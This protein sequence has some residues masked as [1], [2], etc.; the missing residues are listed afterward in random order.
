VKYFLTINFIMMFGY[1]LSIGSIAQA[2][3]VLAAPKNGPD[4]N[5]PNSVT[6]KQQTLSPI[7]PTPYTK[8]TKLAPRLIGNLRLRYE[9]VDQDDI[10]NAANALTLRYRGTLETD[11]GF[12][13]TV[14]GEIEA[15]GAIVTDF[16]DGSGNR[17]DRPVIPEPDGIEVNRL[18]LLTQIN[19]NLRITSGRQ[20]IIIDDERFIGGLAFR[21]N[22][23]TFDSIRINTKILDDVLIDAAYIGRTQ[24]ILGKNNP[25]GEFKGDSFLININA[26][27]PLG[28]I[29]AFHY[30]LD[31]EAGTNLSPNLG[32]NDASVQTTGLRLIGRRHW[33]DWGVIWEGSYAWQSD[34][35]DS[36]LDFNTD[37][38][39]AALNLNRGAASLDLRAEIL[40]SDQG[41]Q[42]FQTPLGTLHK[43]QGAAD[44]FL[45]TPNAGLRDFSTGLSW[46]FDPIGPFTGIKAN[47]TYHWFESD[48]GNHDLGTEID[49]SFGAKYNR[50]GFA[51]DYAYYKANQ[52]SV[53]TRKIFLTTRYPF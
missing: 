48:V 11:I 28:R 34:H 14:L 5:P 6:Q 19:P 27:S 50:V 32:P 37:Y 1:T 13:S 10:P 41:R 43:F 33:Q 24:R 40:G 44:I 12:N 46:Q 29:S 49:L 31:L 15:I 52:F 4:S 39:L 9:N 20:R 8:T 25:L 53:D 16:N 3:H 23:Q 26:P 36:Q 7:T 45:R 21:Q 38:A 22:D 30:A 35:G 42:G 17:P 2:E 47:A 18:Q 51:I